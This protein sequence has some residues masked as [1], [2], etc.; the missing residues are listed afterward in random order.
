MET[1]NERKWFDDFIEK[2]N[3]RLVN[4]HKSEK[5]NIEIETYTVGSKIILLMVHEKNTVEPYI[6]S[7]TTNHIAVTLKTLEEYIS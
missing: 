7:D 3:G 1:T 6:V 5:N 2:H 4:L